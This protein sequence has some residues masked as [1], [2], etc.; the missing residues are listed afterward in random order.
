MLGTD[1]G[2]G[3]ASGAIFEAVKAIWILVNVS[4]LC[5][6]IGAALIHTPLQIGGQSE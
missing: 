1:F 6:R 2:I 5:S 3:V 4:P